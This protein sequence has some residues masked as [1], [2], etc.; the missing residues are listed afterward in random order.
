MNIKTN[1]VEKLRKE[2]A[3]NFVK[4]NP[5]SSLFRMHDFEV[6]G[7]ISV[8]TRMLG[9]NFERYSRR[10]SRKK[11]TNGISGKI[12]AIDFLDEYINNT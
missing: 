11:N 4:K 5:E 9:R 1:G 7:Q 2:R 12:I 6:R 3:R 10:N 8:V